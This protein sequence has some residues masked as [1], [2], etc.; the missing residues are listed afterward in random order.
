MIAVRAPRIETDRLRLRSHRLDD[1]NDSFAMWRDPAVT[2][3]IGGRPSSEQ[4]VWSRLL[5]YAGHWALMGFG[6]WAVEERKSR[7]FVGEI[8]FADFKRDIDP[9]MRD[10]PEAGWA[11]ASQFHGRGYATEALTAVVG[12]G[13]AHLRSNRTVCLIHPDNVASIHMAR[14]SGFRE[15]ARTAFNDRPA[16]FYER[17]VTTPEVPSLP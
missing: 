10:V 16:I 17:L 13:D 8:G 4:Q 2:L 9:L 6:Y 5:T 7:R 3:Y 14:R 15:F 1:F 11:L 12:W